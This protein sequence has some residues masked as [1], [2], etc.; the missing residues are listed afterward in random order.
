MS[1]SFCLNKD[2][3][4]LLAGFGLLYQTLELDRRGKLIQDSQR[5]LCTVTSMLERNNANGASEFKKVA[6]AMISVDRSTKNGRAAKAAGPRR[7]SEGVMHAPKGNIKA[8]RRLSTIASSPAVKPEA[9]SGRRF[10][11]P[12]LPRHSWPGKPRN[13]G[14]QSL[15]SVLSVSTP[16]YANS[17]PNITANVIEQMH[18]LNLPNLDYLDFNTDQSSHSDQISPTS[19]NVLKTPYNEMP[20]CSQPPSDSLFPSLDLFPSNSPG[21]QFDWTSDQWTM[22]TDLVPATQSALSF[23]EE[24]LTSGEDLSS[25]DTNGTFNGIKIPQDSPIAGL[26]N[27]E[28]RVGL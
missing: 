13:N 19:T 7:K 2:E 27:L 9:S 12:T 5:L 25:C 22:P 3:I 24:E 14:Q 17:Q 23:S 26:D 4:L 11:M 21:A 20:G 28:G 1:F 18:A 8:S 16:Q 6:S 10:T 15:S